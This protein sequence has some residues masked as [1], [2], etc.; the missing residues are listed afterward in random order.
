MWESLGA[1]LI[2]VGVKG[3]EKKGE[4]V[5]GCVK[6]TYFTLLRCSLCH[7]TSCDG[8]FCQSIVSVVMLFIYG[9]VTLM[10]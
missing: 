1:P 5:D 8:S 2:E 3:I 9:Q 6:L 4:V 7:V 10:E